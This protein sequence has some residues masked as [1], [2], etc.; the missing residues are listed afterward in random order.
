MKCNICG[1]VAEL[2]DQGEILQR[3]KIQYSITNVRRVVLFLRKRRIGWKKHILLLL[4][5]LMLVYY[6]EICGCI[7][8]CKQ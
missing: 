7:F 2:F 4:Q 1:A 5:S 6:I 8:Y 3:Y